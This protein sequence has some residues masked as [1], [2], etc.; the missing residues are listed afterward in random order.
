MKFLRC[1]NSVFFTTVFLI[2]LVTAFS[3]RNPFLILVYAILALYVIL[4]N[5]EMFRESN[6]TE[7]V[8]M[9]LL[10]SCITLLLPISCIRNGSALIHYLVVLISLGAAF[11][12][13]R[14][15]DVYLTANR[16]SLLLT[17]ATVFIYLFLSGFRWFGSEEGQLLEN[18]LPHSS[19]NVVTSYM[20][21][22]QAS[23]SILNFLLARNPS[24]T[25]SVITLFICIVGFGRGSILASIMIVLVN[26]LS[27]LSWESFTRGVVSII[28]GMGVAMFLFSIYSEGVSAFLYENTK[29]AGGM[30]DG[31]RSQMI[32]DYMSQI[33]PITFITGASY[34]D[35]SIELEFNDNPHNSFIRA[36]HIFGLPY[37]LSIMLFPIS[38][39]WNRSRTSINAYSASML[40]VIFFR[41]FTEPI[42]FP[43]PLDFYFFAL[44]FALNHNGTI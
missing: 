37:L 18:M 29:L 22:L 4:P 31:A 3:T 41:A 9:V 17:Q 40:L 14:K 20:I 28:V 6:S 2:L 43:T 5:L 42:L 30:Y 34:K 35:T 24:T 38:L 19:Q 15:L 44:F 32:Q 25:T 12:L 26:V 8:L 16:I 1:H 13:T 7:R 11:V 33:D 10:I 36:H 27:Y 23:Y 21:L 39:L